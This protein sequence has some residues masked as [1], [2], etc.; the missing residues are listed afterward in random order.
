MKKLIL[1]LIMIGLCIGADY[2]KIAQS[3][4]G[5]PARMISRAPE[6]SPGRGVINEIGDS[7]SLIGPQG[8]NIIVAP[9]GVTLGVLYGPPSDPYDANQPFA[10]VYVA[11]ST[12]MGSSWAKYGPFSIASPLRRMYC[13]IDGCENFHVEA[14]NTFFDWQEGQSGYDPTLNYTMLDENIPS[15][16]SFSSPVQLSGDLDGWHMGIGVNPDDNLHVVASA[17]SYLANGDTANY[18]WVSTDGGYSWTA[19]I[20]VTP[21]IAATC[22]DGAG[23]FRFGSGGYIFFTYQDSYMSAP[24]YPHYV[25]STDGGFTWSAPAQLPALSSTQ[26]WWTELDCEVINDRPYAYHGDLEGLLQ[27]FYPDPDD[28]GSIG[29]WNWV[30]ANVSA[31]GSGAFVYQGT[32]WTLTPIQYPS[33]AYEPDLDVIIYTYKCGYEIAPP[34]AGWTDGNYI[35]GIVSVDGGR[36]WYPTRPLSGPVLQAVGGGTETAH[37]LVTVNDTTYSY[38]TWEDA[39]DGVVGNQYFELGIVMAVQD[40]IFGPGYGIAEHDDEDVISDNMLDIFPTVVSN[41]CHIACNI[42]I[43]GHVHIKTYDA[44]GRLVTTVFSGYLDTGS[45]TI[46]MNTSRLANGVYLVSFESATGTE[47]GKIIIHH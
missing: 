46:D 5:D 21:S 19:P 12:D 40:T 2:S 23:H 29:A 34:P 28:P 33:I 35:G 9:D 11:Y 39:G 1:F 14:G 24:Q 18:C 10:G 32:T 8:K 15:S 20:Q 38:S 45:H 4:E 42:V 7:R 41:N 22:Y 26:F 31:L 43:P 30:A 37:R 44:T 25:E 36:N 13:G 16:P 6:Y 3:R 27:I 47:V 17:M